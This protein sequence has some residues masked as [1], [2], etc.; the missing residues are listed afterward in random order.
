VR[1][2]FVVTVVAGSA[3]LLMATSNSASS[4]S[5]DTRAG[6]SIAVVGAG[7]P[8]S[9]I[10]RRYPTGRLQQLTA[11]REHAPA[12]SRDGRRIAF[13]RRDSAEEDPFVCALFVMNSD[14]SDLH[15]VGSVTT[16]CSRV[17][18]APETVAS[19]SVAE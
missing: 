2:V 12:W 5:R 6:G 18:W 14:G 1:H 7:F 17:S 8:E 16:D 11:T 10:Y 9:G 19:S 4:N 15:R 13:V 3:A